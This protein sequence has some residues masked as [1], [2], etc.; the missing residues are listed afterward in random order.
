[1]KTAVEEDLDRADDESPATTARNPGPCATGSS[2]L[3]GVRRVAGRCGT[4][5]VVGL[6]PLRVATGL[7]AVDSGVFGQPLESE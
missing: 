2:R 6:R 7:N 3:S 4:E 1:M 5:L